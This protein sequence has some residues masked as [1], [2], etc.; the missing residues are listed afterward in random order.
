[1]NQREVTWADI[2]AFVLIEL[3]SE[4][5]SLMELDHPTGSHWPKTCET[6]LIHRRKSDKGIGGSTVGAG[7]APRNFHTMRVEERSAADNRCV[8]TGRYSRDCNTLSYLL[9]RPLSS[10]CWLDLMLPQIGYRLNTSCSC[11]RFVRQMERSFSVYPNLTPRNTI[12]TARSSRKDE[13]RS[14][15]V[16][17]R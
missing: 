4:C 6:R 8:N 5:L 2:V 11:A 9:S 15:R 12:F 3:N 7:S 13:R 10:S 17:R 1:M 14:H 16:S